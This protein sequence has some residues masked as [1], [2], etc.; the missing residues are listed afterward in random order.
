MHNP[1]KMRILWFNWRDIK[2]PEAG[3]A[4]VLTH[5]VML[6]LARMGYDMTLFCPSI[7]NGLNKEEIDGVKIIRSGGNIQFIIRRKSFTR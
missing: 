3:G 4:E 1:Q 7:P 6:R 5:E 2:H